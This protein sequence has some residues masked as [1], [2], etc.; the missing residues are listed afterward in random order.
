M[1]VLLCL[2]LF[3]GTVN[4]QTNNDLLIELAVTYSNYSLCQQKNELLKNKVVAY[5]NVYELEKYKHEVYRETVKE[6]KKSSFWN[7]VIFLILFCGGV[8]LGLYAK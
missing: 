8:G 2:V 4:G 3:A 6:N 7:T 1:T 5:S